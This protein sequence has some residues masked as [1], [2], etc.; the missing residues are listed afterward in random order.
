MSK[1]ETKRINW[2]KPKNVVLF[3]F[4]V[5]SYVRDV[6]GRVMLQFYQKFID[7]ETKERPFHFLLSERQVVNKQSRNKP[8]MY[9]KGSTKWWSNR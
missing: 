8:V 5:I 6:I 7:S 4:L 1:F 2:S 9:K 3:S